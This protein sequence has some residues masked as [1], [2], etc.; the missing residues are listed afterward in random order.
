MPDIFSVLET[1]RRP[2]LLM[3]AARHGMHAYRRG[4]DLGRLIGH[5]LTPAH[6]IPQLITAEERLER[7]RL[8]GEA[9]YSP[10]QHVQLLTALIA[11][12][13]RLPRLVD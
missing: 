5:D 13:S 10:L 1:I 4:R 7:N 9:D 2:R 12:A 8:S 11:E 3:Q 6:A